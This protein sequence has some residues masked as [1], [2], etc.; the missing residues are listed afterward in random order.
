MPVL[1][2]FA[3]GCGGGSDSLSQTAPQSARVIVTDVQLSADKKRVE[4]ITVVKDDGEE[5]TMKLGEE[6][7]PA[8]W[9]PNHLL[10][11]A[12]SGDS[13]GLTSGVAYVRSGPSVVATQ[14]SE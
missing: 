1:L 10:L 8:D 12:G 13:L 5:L 11:H 14:L 9:D 6:I 3:V 4:Y 2:V 7:E